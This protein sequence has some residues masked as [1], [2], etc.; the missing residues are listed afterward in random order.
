MLGSYDDAE[1]RILAVL[2][3]DWHRPGDRLLG[4]EDLKQFN[5]AVDHKL[6]EAIVAD[7]DGRGIVQAVYAKDGAAA[8][9]KPSGY[10]E[11]SAILFRELGDP[12][13]FTVDW[14]KGEILSEAP[15]PDWFPVPTGWKWFQVVPKALPPGFPRRQMPEAPKPV[16]WQKWS[17]VVTAIGIVVAAA[18]AIKYH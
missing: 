18:V 5:A 10:K 3:M 4:V 11:A 17:V 2:L 6:F 9:L 1:R 14:K 12:E 7:L 8:V 13:T 15:A 16:D